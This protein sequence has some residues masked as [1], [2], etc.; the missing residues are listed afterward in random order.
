[1]VLY[2]FGVSCG[3]RISYGEIISVKCVNKRDEIKMFAYDPMYGARRITGVATL[4]AIANDHLR[5]N[6]L[7]VG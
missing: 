7:P 2:R 5:Y 4:L 3:R 1:M 6:I